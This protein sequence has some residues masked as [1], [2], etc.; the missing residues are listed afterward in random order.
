[1]AGTLA[2][3]GRASVRIMTR[4]VDLLAVFYLMWGALALVAGT[5]ILML[6]LGALAIVTSA[7]RA[8]LGPDVAASLT[9][10]L[11]FMFAAAA[12]AWGGIHLW[13]GFSLRKHRAWA[14]L[15][16]L[17]L[18]VLNL[19]FLPLGTALAVYT[20]WVLLSEPTRRLFEPGTP[21][22]APGTAVDGQ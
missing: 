7:T 10:G 12:L 13:T 17:A 8:A 18:A 22:A 3:G 19:F 20:F 14:R 9:V 21:V 2:Q 6:A 5:A 1:V 11:F 16:G 15:T 4:H